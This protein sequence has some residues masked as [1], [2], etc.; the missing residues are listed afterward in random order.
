[1]LTRIV[2]IIVVLTGF[3][4]CFALS[5]AVPAGIFIVRHGE[6]LPDI[7]HLSTKGEERAAALAPYF[8]GTYGLTSNNV[9][10]VYAAK[11]N[12]ESIR[13]VQTCTPLANLFKQPVNSEFKDEDYKQ[14]AQQILTNANY[15]GKFV[16]ICWKHHVIPQLAHALG[17]IP[18]PRKWHNNI[19][20]RVWVIHYDQAGKVTLFKNLPQKLLFGDSKH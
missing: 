12:A 5:F 15:N 17:I 13:P 3:M 14:A 16:I 18:Q 7:D 19:F 4:S 6:K 10:A 8:A 2:K 20:D 11:S 1:M 9:A